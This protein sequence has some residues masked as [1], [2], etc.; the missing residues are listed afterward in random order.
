MIK[1]AFPSERWNG[2]DRR[3]DMNRRSQIEGG[4]NWILPKEINANLFF[5][6]SYRLENLKNM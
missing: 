1:L 2:R 4:K 5:W 6:D 3:Y